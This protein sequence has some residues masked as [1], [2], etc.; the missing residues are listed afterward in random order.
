M[1]HSWRQ[2]C[3]ICYF[4]QFQKWIGKTAEFQKDQS[5]MVICG[6]RP[7]R[8]SQPP[9]LVKPRRWVISEFMY[10]V[11]LINCIHVY[12]SHFVSV[13]LLFLP[14]AVVSACCALLSCHCVRC[15][16]VALSVVCIWQIKNEWMKWNYRR[17]RLLSDAVFLDVN[18]HFWLLLLTYIPYLWPISPMQCFYRPANHGGILSPDVPIGTGELQRVSAIIPAFTRITQIRLESFWRKYQ[19]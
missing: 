1:E 2:N 17:I 19:K 14:T 18:Y 15:F 9:F 3:Y 7:L 16:V 13:I 4:E 6:Q 12:C 8:P 5:V 11:F 10:F